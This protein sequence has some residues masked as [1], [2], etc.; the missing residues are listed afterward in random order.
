MRLSSRT[1]LASLFLLAQSALAFHHHDAG[2]ALRA[3]E[4]SRSS[5]SIEAQ[6]NCAL[7]AFQIQPRTSTPEPVA[8]AEA[9]IVVAVLSDATSE[10]PR[11]A[12]IGRVSARAPPAV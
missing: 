12:R 11:A 3:A 8:L 2:L 10:T 1:V 7:C 4:R 9:P 5:T 6:D